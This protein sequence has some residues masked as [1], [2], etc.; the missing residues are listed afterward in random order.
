MTI[1]SYPFNLE[2]VDYDEFWDCFDD[3]DET[4]VVDVKLNTV[5]NGKFPKAR[6][7]YRTGRFTRKWLSFEPDGKEYTFQIGEHDNHFGKFINIDMVYFLKEQE[8][9]IP[10]QRSNYWACPTSIDPDRKP[11]VHLPTVERT[12]VDCWDV[13]WG[14][15]QELRKYD[16]KSLMSM[17]LEKYWDIDRMHWIGPFSIGHLKGLAEF[18]DYHQGPFLDFI[19]DRD[20]SKGINKIIFADGNH[21][22]LVGC[23]SMSATHKGKYFGFEPEGGDPMPYVMDFWSCDGEKLVDNWCQIDMLQLFMNINKEYN[24]YLS[25]IFE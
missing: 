6:C 21:A 25:S 18:R 2:N 12:E 16:G 4:V 5:I 10:W 7:Y 9:K 24:G 13:V 20:G 11:K 8:V 3:V 19:P 1:Y 15:I 23:H 17:N 14:M 22:A